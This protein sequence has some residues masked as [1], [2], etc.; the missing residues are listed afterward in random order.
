MAKVKERCNCVVYEI[1]VVYFWY[2]FSPVRV[3][4]KLFD[5]MGVLLYYA[6]VYTFGLITGKLLE[7]PVA[8]HNALFG[9]CFSDN[10]VFPHVNEWKST[11]ASALVLSKAWGSHFTGFYA[12]AASS[13]VGTVLIL[14]HTDIMLFFSVE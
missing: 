4:T 8:T 14:R 12:R 9:L 3:V 13:Q 1:N 7:A 6:D 11:P 10:E 2:F 5:Q